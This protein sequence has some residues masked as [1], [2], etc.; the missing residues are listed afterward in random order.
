MKEQSTSIQSEILSPKELRRYAFQ[1]KMGEMGVNGQERIKQSKI[2]VIGAGGK[3]TAAL[4]N[5]VSVGV[6]T[7]GISDNYPVLE[8]ELSR[9]HLYGSN[10]LGKQKA[11]IARQ[12]L[13]EINQM[14]NFQLHN[15]CLS[16]ENIFNICEPYDA[17]VDATDNYSAHA[18]I[19]EAAIKMNKPVI[20][21]SVKGPEGLVSVFNYKEGPSFRCAFPDPESLNPPYQEGA[22]ACQIALISMVGAAMANETIKVLLE[23]DTALNGKVLTI[24]A[25]SYSFVKKEVTKNPKNFT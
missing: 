4:E 21:G 2:L 5:L 14:V 17:L 11:I 15:V 19:N 23:A 3:G 1:I 25:R 18:L 13:Q 16:K 20:F 7:L 8:S 22:F 24:D 10:D 6:G 12:K 9:Q